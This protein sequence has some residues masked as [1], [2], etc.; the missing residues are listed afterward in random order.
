MT[1][2]ADRIHAALGQLRTAVD[3]L[4]RGV[5]D[6]ESTTVEEAASALAELRDLISPLRQCEAGLERWIATCFRHEG[7]DLTHELVGV[8]MVEVRR[9]VTRRGWDWDE[10]KSAW[11][12]AYMERNGGEVTDPA[13]IR[14]ALFESFSV[15]GGKVTGLRELGIDANDYASVE[16]GPPRVVIC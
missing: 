16:P 6:V 9:S 8:G 12:N 15:S 13:Q 2:A 4:N 14:D 10:L 1:T 11:L 7:W 3:D 5:G